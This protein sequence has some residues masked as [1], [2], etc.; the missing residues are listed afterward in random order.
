MFT[1]THQKSFPRLISSV[2]IGVF[3]LLLL[4][5]TTPAG[6]YRYLNPEAVADLTPY[7]EALSKADMD[8]YRYVDERNTILFE[9]GLK[10][11]LL[12]ANEMTAQGMSVRLERVRTAKPGFDTGSVFRLTPDGGIVEIM[13]KTKVK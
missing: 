7:T 3:S 5:F 2:I 10:V 6:S 8:R 4:S 1:R 13:T 9:S 11:E 12:S